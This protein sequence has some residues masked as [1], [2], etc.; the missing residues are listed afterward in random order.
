MLLF[1]VFHPILSYRNKNPTNT[2]F[3]GVFGGSGA[4]ENLLENIRF[5]A[6]TVF[7]RTLKANF[8]FLRDFENLAFIQMINLQCFFLIF[9]P[10]LHDTIWNK[11]TGFHRLFQYTYIQDRKIK[12]EL[13][14][15]VF[16]DSV[17]SD[18]FVILNIKIKQDSDIS[19][20]SLC[21]TQL[22]MSDF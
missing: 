8:Q 5:W 21:V 13:S 2:Y 22:N 14:I 18:D 7:L 19:V 10:H 12:T 1:R 9:C 11:L 20:E 3:L 15:L 16:N 4:E 17:N 6:T